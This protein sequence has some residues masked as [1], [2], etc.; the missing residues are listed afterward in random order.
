MRSPRSDGFTLV[1]VVIALSILAFALFGS[2][3]AITYCTRM[4]SVTRERMLALRAAER[5]IEQ[6]LS[7]GD[8]TQIYQNYSLQAQGIGWDV[9]DGLEPID[10]APL[11][12][13]NDQPTYVYPS[14]TN[15]TL[16]P[17]PR[18]VLFVRFPL[19]QD[20]SYFSEGPDGTFKGSGVMTDTYQVD[21]KGNR[22]KDGGGNIIPQDFDFN[23]NGVVTDK[24]LVSQVSTLKLLPVTIEVYWKSA[25]N[26]GRNV[27]P[28]YLK[29]QYIFFKDPLK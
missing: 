15:K 14:W 23:G 10:P 1:E 21:A 18:A 12:P 27:G 16:P 8:F 9:V 4:N 13:P 28:A 20:G 26:P 7:V 5:K 22:V 19:S 11:P 3:S 2:I 25:A 24:I 17:P 6:M 29:Y